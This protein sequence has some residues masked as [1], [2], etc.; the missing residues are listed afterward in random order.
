MEA[1]LGWIGELIGWF[2]A[3]IPRLEIILATERGVKFVRGKKVVQIGPGLR[4]YWPAMTE[5]KTCHVNRQALLLDPLTLTTKD[6]KSVIAGGIVVYTIDDVEKY[7]VENYDADEA[8][9]DVASSTLK[10]AITTHS[11]EDLCEIGP[12]LDK[13]L[14]RLVRS[15]LRSYGVKVEYARMRDFAATRVISLVGSSG[16]AIPLSEI[17]D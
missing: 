2:A 1:A 17:D 6:Q 11:F 13:L 9:E 15:S 5:I 10:E 12:D 14:T 16:N 4:W 7:L 8:I 3:W